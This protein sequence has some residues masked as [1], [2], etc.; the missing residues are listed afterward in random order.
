MTAPPAT[1]PLLNARR[2]RH[3]LLAWLAVFA[4]WGVPTVS[5]GVSAVQ[6]DARGALC[7]ATAADAGGHGQAASGAPTPDRCEL[8]VLAVLA[9]TLPPRSLQQG[10][11]LGVRQTAPAAPAVDGRRVL[12][13][14]R[15][16][17]PRAPPTPFLA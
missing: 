10:L 7:S 16:A 9:A 15:P 4:L 13:P 12:A 6:D 8:C 17:L 1:V 14:W 11:D 2:L 3:A 5:R